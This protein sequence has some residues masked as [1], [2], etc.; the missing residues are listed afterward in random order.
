MNLIEILSTLEG[1]KIVAVDQYNGTLAAWNMSST[2][3]F[4]AVTEDTIDEF[5]I[6]TLG[7]VPAS[8]KEARQSA[9]RKLEQFACEMAE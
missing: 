2:I 8:D 9:H 5:D 7:E 1:H 6:I 4:F 3:R